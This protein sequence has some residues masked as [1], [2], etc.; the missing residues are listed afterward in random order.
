M[1]IADDVR[2]AAKSLSSASE[3]SGTTGTTPETVAK[4][5][6][7]PTGTSGTATGRDAQGRFAPKQGDKPAENA[8]PAS[9]KSATE[10]APAAAA[11]PK[12]GPPKSFRPTVHG[13]WEKVPTEVQEE[14]LRVEAATQ[15][16][17]KRFSQAN[18]T[19]KQFNDFLSGY[20][21]YI[22]GDP[23]Q[24]L[25][26]LAQTAVRLQ[27]A[28][29][30][31]RAAVLA[32]MARQ[33]D[34]E[35]D[36]LDDALAGIFSG[37]ATPQPAQRAQHEADNPL[38]TRIQELE[39]R[40]S[41]MSLAPMLEAF[42]KEAEFLDEPIPGRDDLKVRDMVAHHLRTAAQANLALTPQ[43]AYAQVIAAHPTIQAVLKQR[44]E[45]K[46]AAAQQQSTARA[47]AA[48]RSVR[49]EHVVASPSTG[50]KGRTID[51]VRATAQMLRSRS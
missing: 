47:E 35:V 15:E 37:Q 22:Q 19:H 9:P 45:A 44:E 6:P 11:P 13:H 10:G 36:D 4:A 20:R 51:D 7:E 31:D 12:R 43:E 49:T 1:S 8:A 48:S 46:A 14:V 50:S 33:F 38:M 21:P 5:V 16:L 25:G 32:Q 17:A 24:W 27:T 28:P 23:F 34:V 41:H 26:S 40:L 2:E 3:P 42:T 39:Q 30:R 18:N 29:K